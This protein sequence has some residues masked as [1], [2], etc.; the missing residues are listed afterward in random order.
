MNTF[1][2]EERPY[3]T[4]AVA[5]VLEEFGSGRESVLLESPVGSGKTVMGLLIIKQLQEQAGGKLRVNWVASRRHILEQTQDLNDSFFHCDVN[6]VSVFASNPPKADLVVLDEA[7]HEA[8]Q[9]CLDMYENTGNTRTLGLSATPMRT[10]RM[11][12]SFQTSVRCC[13]I[14]RL[15]NMGVLSQYHSCKLPEWNVE[16]V[17]KVFC[18][19]PERWDKT[20]VFFQTIRECQIFKSILAGYGIGCEVVTAQSNRDSQLDA[21]IAGDVQVVANVS[22]LSEGFDLPELQSVFLRDAS[23]LPTIQMAG[24]GLRRAEG[25]TH[26]NL[27]QSSTSP[28]PVERIALPAEGFR[29]MKNKWLSCSGNT[30]VILD[31]L[32]NSMK[33]LAERKVHLPRYL[34]SGRHVKEVSLRTLKPFSRSSLSQLFKITGE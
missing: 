19:A 33:L 21:F 2:F 7:H 31:T 13:G 22:V 6:M 16:L 34:S 32:E 30:Q 14:Q 24:R 17:A 25:K 12:L 4:E 8:T 10:D 5:R 9:S 11:R 29:Y 28:Y 23:R 15:I 27:V 18:E 20:L 1:I 3:Q 26:C